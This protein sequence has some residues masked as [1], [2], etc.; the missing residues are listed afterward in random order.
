[1]IE[2]KLIIGIDATNLNY[3]GGK[4]HLIELLS[5]ANPKQHNFSKIIVWSSTETLNSIDDKDWIIKISPFRKNNLVVRLFWQSFLLSKEARKLKCNVLFIPGGIYLG[6]FDQVV[7]MSQNLLPFVQKEYE[8]YNFTLKRFKLLLLKHIQS[9]SFKKAKG[10]IFL[11]YHAKKTIQ[12]FIGNLNTKSAIIPHGLNKRFI[13]NV[14]PNLKKQTNAAKAIKILYVSHIELYKHQWIVIEG[15]ARLRKENYNICLN[16]VGS[17]GLGIK[18]LK[19][20]MKKYDP[21]AEWIFYQDHVDYDKIHITYQNF[22]F[23]IFASSCENLPIT[24]LEMIGGKMKIACSNIKPMT[25]ILE[26][27]GVYFDPLNPNSIADSMRKLINNEMLDVVE[28]DDEFLKK[29]IEKYNWENTAKLT[30]DFLNQH[31]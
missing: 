31:R 1:M 27:R 19:T 16:L 28:I 5:V 17:A 23:G 26:N 13:G 3:G 15:L 11:T 2:S 22:N 12:N 8:R 18:K 10:V 6:N 25:E 4:A 7:T 29:F 9:Y 30:F 20:A 14:N 21:N 24:L